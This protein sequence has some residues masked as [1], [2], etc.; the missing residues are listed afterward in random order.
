MPV[1]RAFLKQLPIAIVAAAFIRRT[2]AAVDPPSSGSG[3]K[4]NGFDLK[5]QL[6]TGLKARRPSDF[7]YI[8][9]IVTKVQN[10]TLPRTLVDQSFLFARQQNSDYPIVYFQFCLKKLAQKAGVAL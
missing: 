3:G 8:N 4:P 6:E 10:G 9:W 1:R 2:A 7:S 5:K